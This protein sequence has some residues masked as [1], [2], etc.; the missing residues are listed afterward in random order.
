MSVFVRTVRQVSKKEKQLTLSRDF[1]QEIYIIVSSHKLRLPGNRTQLDS[2]FKMKSEITSSCTSDSMISLLKPSSSSSKKQH[3]PTVPSWHFP[4]LLLDILEDAE[5]N[6][7][8]HIV[9]WTPDG[10]AFKV[11]KRDL[12]MK[13]I[14]PNYF[15]LTKYNSFARQLQLW[16]FAFCKGD[17]ANPKFGACKCLTSSCSQSPSYGGL[18]TQPAP[19]TSYQIPTPALY[20]AKISAACRQSSESRSK[21]D[22]PVEQRDR[23]ARKPR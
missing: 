20:G 2:Y 5:N 6:G 7:N 15:G 10:A 3:F 16:G 23:R 21:E 8:E 4:R 13:Q 14:L 17:C 18:C 11:H 22:R 12:F 9:S 19:S 1:F